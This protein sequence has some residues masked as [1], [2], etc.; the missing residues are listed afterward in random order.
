MRKNKKEMSELEKKYQRFLVALRTTLWS[1]SVS[2]RLV[3]GQDPLLALQYALA[4][5]FPPEASCIGS[6]VSDDGMVMIPYSD[7][8]LALYRIAMQPEN[9]DHHPDSDDLHLVT[10]VLDRCSN[11]EFRQFVRLTNR[12]HNPNQL[13]RRWA[14]QK[15]VDI[16]KGVAPEHEPF[17]SPVRASWKKGAR[18]RLH[19]LWKSGQLDDDGMI[20]KLLGLAKADLTNA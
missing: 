9:S 6:C 10:K 11:H 8:V 3:N 14:I 1:S 7:L 18:R 17:A 12:R 15:L 13:T 19:E 4:K 5:H 2:I 16:V 20:P